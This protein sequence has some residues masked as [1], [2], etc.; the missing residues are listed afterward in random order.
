MH[1]KLPTASTTRSCDG[2][3]ILA[4]LSD[5][6]KGNET[7]HSRNAM[8]GVLGDDLLVHV[9]HCRG[10]MKFIEY[11]QFRDN[12]FTFPLMEVVAL[13]FSR[14]LVVVMTDSRGAFSPLSGHFLMHL[15]ISRG[16]PAR[17]IFL[18]CMFSRFAASSRRPR[19]IPKKVEPP[20]PQEIGF[21]AM[22]SAAAEF[23]PRKADDCLESLYPP[24]HLI[25][26]PANHGIPESAVLSIRCGRRIVAD[27]A[28]RISP[29][30]FRCVVQVKPGPRINMAMARIMPRESRL[31]INMRAADV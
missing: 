28:A 31:S 6:L 1:V 9:T 5:F 19:E 26:A 11:N 3:R 8:V 16:F 24:T 17:S 18:Y 23:G 27:D 2:R 22:V 30:S 21:F 14:R 29:V 10:T 12:T 20:K 13:V 4:E 7:W 25:R 15:A